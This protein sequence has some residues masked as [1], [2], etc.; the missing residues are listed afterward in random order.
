V[1]QS[2]IQAINAASDRPLNATAQFTWIGRAEPA[3]PPNLVNPVHAVVCLI[4][5][6]LNRYHHILHQHHSATTWQTTAAH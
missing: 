5:N 3:N 6:G 2:I 1:F 4:F